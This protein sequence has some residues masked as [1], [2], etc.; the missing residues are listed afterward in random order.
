MSKRSELELAQSWQS[1]QFYCSLGILVQVDVP[2]P[3]HLV[4]SIRT[5]SQVL[6]NLNLLSYF[7]STTSVDDQG[8]THV[9]LPGYMQPHTLSSQ[10]VQL[11]ATTL[12]SRSRQLKCPSISNPAL[13]T[14]LQWS[15]EQHVCRWSSKRGLLPEIQTGNHVFSVII[16]VRIQDLQEVSCVVSGEV[17]HVP[18]SCWRAAFLSSSQS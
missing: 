9:E 14:S 18:L 16:F 11:V 4:E 12:V 6:V 15:I 1:P 10:I 7:A 17:E 8:N 5:P 13:L 3:G 2:R